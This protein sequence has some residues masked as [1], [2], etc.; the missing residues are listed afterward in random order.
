MVGMKSSA[1]KSV[2]QCLK[3]YL[4]L[5]IFQIRK[6]SFLAAWHNFNSI[7]WVSLLHHCYNLKKDSLSQLFHLEETEVQAY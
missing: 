3:L 2:R 7:I 4:R 6:Q 1:F 5:L